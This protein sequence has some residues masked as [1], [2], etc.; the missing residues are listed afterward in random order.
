MNSPNIDQKQT[1]TVPSPRRLPPGDDGFQSLST[2]LR[3]ETLS[4]DQLENLHEAL[5]LRD[6]FDGNKNSG[7]ENN[8]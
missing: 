6:F 3:G 8:S 1:D 4:P 5:L 7:T 2:T